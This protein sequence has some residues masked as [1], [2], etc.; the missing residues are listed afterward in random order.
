LLLEPVF[1]FFLVLLVKQVEVNHFYVCVVLGFE[2]RALHLLYRYSTHHLCS[3]SFFVL[4]IFQVGSCIF[5]WDQPQTQSSYLY[6]LCNWDHRNAPPY[7]AFWLKWSLVNF[8]PRLA[9][10]LNPLNLCLPSSWDYRCES[11]HLVIIKPLICLIFL[12][13]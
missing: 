10:N 9:S 12:F 13:V 8:L 1:N 3:Q 4:V 5:A 11:P 6:L 7:P 2:L